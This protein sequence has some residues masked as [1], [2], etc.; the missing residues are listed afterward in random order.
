MSEIE[1]KPERAFVRARSFS[2]IASALAS[3]LGVATDGLDILRHPHGGVQLDQTG[4]TSGD[5]YFPFKATHTDRGIYIEPGLLAFAGRWWLLGGE[6]FSVGTNNWL[7]YI[8]L[9]VSPQ[10]IELDPAHPEADWHHEMVPIVGA[11]GSPNLVGSNSFPI[12]DRH[13]T[14]AEIHYLAAPPY[15]TFLK[16]IL[17]IPIAGSDDGNFVQFART[18][19]QV[20][21]HSNGTVQVTQ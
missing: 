21:A 18:N 17:R 6:S 14:P 11:S 7:V 20:W 3:R 5:E 15:R 19:L 12:L 9:T 2:R 16:G 10:G 8:E 1:K 13:P 4:N